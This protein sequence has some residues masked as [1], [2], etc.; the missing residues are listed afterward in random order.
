MSGAGFFFGHDVAGQDHEVG[1]HVLPDHVLQDGPHRLLG[2]GGRHGELPAA[3]PA[4][5]D[6]TR[7]RPG[8]PGS[9]PPA[10][11]CL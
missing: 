5:R 8:A 11:I 7:A 2:G 3:R 1:G 10:I 4:P 6:D 9:R